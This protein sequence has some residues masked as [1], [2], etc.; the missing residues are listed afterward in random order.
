MDFSVTDNLGAPFFRYHNDRNVIL[1]NPPGLS[2]RENPFGG[3]ASVATSQTCIAVLKNHGK[4]NHTT[5]Y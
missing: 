4:R 2:P 3:R 5:C 1:L